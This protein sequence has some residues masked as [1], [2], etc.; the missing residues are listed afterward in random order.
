MLDTA[1][2]YCTHPSQKQ[3]ESILFIRLIVPTNMN[4]ELCIYETSIT[5]YDHNRTTNKLKAIYD[6]I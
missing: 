5:L 4:C 2:V 6:T 1:L 3:I